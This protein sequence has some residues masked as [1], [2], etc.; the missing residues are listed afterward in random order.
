MKN[1]AIIGC[2]GINSWFCKN[3]NEIITNFYSSKDI[4][5]CIYDSDI[6]EEKNILSNN[7]NFTPK[8]V[9][10]YK[11][12]V[13]AKKYNF[14]PYNFDITESNIN[15]L[16]KYDSIILGV[17]NHKTRRMVYKYC[18]ENKKYC[19]DMRA[20]GTQVAFYILD[21]N[22]N[23]QYYDETMFNN[24]LVMEKKGS[25]Q[26]NIDIQNGHIEIGN[27]V[28]A[29]IGTAIFFKYLRNEIPSTDTFEWVY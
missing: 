16:E 10:D 11:V 15:G 22:K 14:I 20:Q 25:C 12:D 6:V 1:V 23:I 2:G 3:L 4:I 19:F 9:M 5:V 17:D 8:D 18:L 29:M 26:L 13:I 24:P 28:I 27:K 7:Q 21:L